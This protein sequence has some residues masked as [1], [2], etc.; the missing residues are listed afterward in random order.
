MSDA[1][2]IV[3]VSD[4]HILTQSV[5]EEIMGIQNLSKHLAALPGP[6]ADRVLAEYIQ[7]PLGFLTRC[8]R[9]FGEIVPIQYRFP[10]G[11]RSTATLFISSV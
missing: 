5:A 3:K 9:D 6:G 4:A 2:I 8:A 7:N 1:R 11:K 10:A